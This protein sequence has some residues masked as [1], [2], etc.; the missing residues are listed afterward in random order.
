MKRW[1]RNISRHLVQAARIP[2]IN[3]VYTIGAPFALPVGM[4]V[5]GLAFSVLVGLSLGLLGG[6]G[7]ILTVP[8][9][10][11]VM[12]IETHAAIASSLIVVG[13][14]SLAALI[15]HARAKRVQ[16]RTGASFGVAAMLG[17]YLA[18]SVAAHI[19]ATILMIVFGI[20]MF[21]TAVAMLRQHTATALNQRN[22][23]SFPLI[24]IEGLVV[25][26]VTGLVGA[27]GGFLVVPALMLLGGLP[28]AEAIGTSLMV[29]AM[30]SF[31][32][33]AGSVGSVTLDPKII[34]SVAT[35]TVGGS[36]LGGWATSKISAARLQG[37]FGWFIVVMAMFILGQ[38]VP[39]ALGHHVELVA[40]W[41]WLLA[42][43]VATTA[44][45]I[46]VST[47]SRVASTPAASQPLEP[48]RH[49][50][51]LFR[52]LFDPTSSTYTYVLADETSREAILIDPVI[53]QVDR[54]LALLDELGLTLRFALDTHV[55]A[56]H[57]T[58]AGT[59]RE[60][61][62]AQTVLSERAGVGCADILVKDGDRIRFGRYG[63]TV[64][65][66][67]GH[68]LGCVTYVLDDETMAFTGDAVLIRGCG[69]TDFQQGDAHALYHSVRDKVFSLPDS[70]LIFPGH[71][72]K[73]RT[74]TSVGE[75][76]LHNPRLGGNRSEQEF[77][78]IM[79]GLDLPY[80]KQLETALPRNLQ[81]GLQNMLRSEPPQWGAP[82]GDFLWGAVE[83]SA[84]GVPEVDVGWV[85]EH[86]DEVTLIDVRE[87]DEFT[88]ELG[89]IDG[90]TLIPLATITPGVRR[91]EFPRGRALANTL[92]SSRRGVGECGIESISRALD[93]VPRDRPTVVVCRSGG[94]SAKAALALIAAGFTKIASMRGGMTD[95][96]ARGLAA[97]R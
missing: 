55:H 41:P 80:P 89:H 91:Q 33:F 93:T 96:N 77:V 38:E 94:R 12:G 44:L 23:A 49:S 8:V 59:L 69:R 90:A 28:I 25:G 83:L 71:D 13:V 42:A 64:R 19:P 7:S 74:A 11:Y 31:A 40:H 22:R 68:T 50:A 26:G 58:A 62:G 16:W 70:T 10:H 5:I 48:S 87:P 2:N 20:V 30:K 47:R 75:E 52:Q 53:D 95:W 27:G 18:G 57:V 67:P 60:R 4:F 45:A 72:Y 63:L 24:L 92:K 21:V 76:K 56:D 85:A 6:G 14:T 73:G 51:M 78:A 79:N 36:I 15:P 17:A 61:R 29:I 3:Q 1:V 65:E 66:T 82:Q 43:V 37:L 35:I 39:R 32:A 97:T 54:D 88:G 46:I 81:C 34:L 86:H 84:A 9:I